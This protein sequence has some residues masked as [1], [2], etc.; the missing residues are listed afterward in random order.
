MLVAA[1]YFFFFGN[2]H[3]ASRSN[4]AHIIVEQ[5]ST[6]QLSQSAPYS[7]CVGHVRASASD[8]IRHRDRLSPTTQHYHHTT[9]EIS[10]SKTSQHRPR[11]S[12]SSPARRTQTSHHLQVQFA[13]E[14]TAPHHK[15][16]KAAQ[17]RNFWSAPDGDQ[18][19]IEAGILGRSW[20]QRRLRRWPPWSAALPSGRRLTVHLA[21]THIN[22]LLALHRRPA[23]PP[24]PRP[25]LLGE[26]LVR[27]LFPQLLLTTMRTTCFATPSRFSL[28]PVPDCL[29]DDQQPPL[30]TSTALLEDHLQGA[31][32]GGVHHLCLASSICF[33]HLPLF[34]DHQQ[35]SNH[36]ATTHTLRPP[37]DTSACFHCSSIEPEDRFRIRFPSVQPPPTP[38]TS[39]S[40][41]RRASSPACDP[42]C[43]SRGRFTAQFRAGVI[44]HWAQD[45]PSTETFKTQQ[46]NT[47]EHTN[48][49]N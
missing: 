16:L 14:A 22:D 46:H 12:L 36:I 31:H 18:R 13:A 10:A 39:T 49:D 27:Q 47:Q 25:L 4:A 41:T 34:A 38:H 32:G 48:H 28:C 37:G 23:S 11:A 33:N 5:Q 9:F 1:L 19:L 17:A 40:N 21:T 29:Y 7:H 35:L 45:T 15:S 20:G 8:S 2:K 3:T 43:Q 26:V 42:R 6:Q 30:L 44:R 24:S